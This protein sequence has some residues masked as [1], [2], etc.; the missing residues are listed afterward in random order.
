MAYLKSCGS[1]G[2]D[3]R[4]GER[5]H[6]GV[7]G[8]ETKMHHLVTEWVYPKKGKIM[9]FYRAHHKCGG[10]CGGGCVDGESLWGWGRWGRG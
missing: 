10:G 4:N 6:W 5:F 8:A 3:L 7:P 1:C 2:K 9:S